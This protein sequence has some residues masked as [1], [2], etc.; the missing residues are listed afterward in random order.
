MANRQVNAPSNA[1]VLS[2]KD[3]G[4]IKATS[5]APNTTPAIKPR[6][7]F[8]IRTVL[9]HFLCAYNIQLE[10]EPSMPS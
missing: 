4:S 1:A 6:I 2:G 9:A 3:I 8:D 5:S 7:T 10:S